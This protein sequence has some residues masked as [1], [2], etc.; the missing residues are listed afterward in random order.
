MAD[1]WDNAALQLGPVAYWPLDDDGVWADATGNGHDLTE[2]GTVA[3]G[4]LADGK[5]GAVFDG[6]TNRLDAADAAPLRPEFTDGWSISAWVQRDGAPGGQADYLGKLQV[7][8]VPDCGFLMGAWTSPEFAPNVKYGSGSGTAGPN[9]GTSNP[10]DRDQY[11]LGAFTAGTTFHMVWTMDYLNGVSTLYIDG[12]P[13][14]LQHYGNSLPHSWGSTSSTVGIPFAI[15]G[16]DGPNA[17]WP[18]KIAKVAYFDKV[19]TQTDVDDLYG[20][21]E[22]PPPAGPGGGEIHPPFNEPYYLGEQDDTS[23]AQG[24]LWTL[25]VGIAGREFMVDVTTRLYERTH[26]NLLRTRQNRQGSESVLTPPEIW[27]SVAE[28]W[29]QGA[30]QTRYDRDESLPY[31]FAD[32][33]GVDVWDE[34]GFSLLNKTTELLTFDGTSFPKLAVIGHGQLFCGYGTRVVWWADPVDGVQTP[35]ELGPVSAINGLTTDGQDVYTAHANGSVLKWE[36]NLAPAAPVSSVF[37]TGITFDGIWYLKGFLVASSGNLLY[38]ISTG[39][40]ALIYTHPNP[41]WRWVAGADG[42]N[43]GYVLGGV[44]DKWFVQALRIKDDATSFDPPFTAAS[45]PEGEVGHALGG[46]LG[47]IL[48]GTDHGVRFAAANQDASLLYGQLIETDQ[49]V[50]CFEGQGR[51][52]WYG[53]RPSGLGAGLGRIDLSVFTAPNTP[54]YANDLRADNAAQVCAH[55]AVSLATEPGVTGGLGYRVFGTKESLWLEIDDKVA[56]G[57]LDLGVLNMDTVD[58]KRAQYAQIT[59]E[60]LEGEVDLA[61]A[62]D[63]L[64]YA[65]VAKSNVQGTVNMGNRLLN[66]RKFVGA[67]PRIILKRSLLDPTAG[68][69]V[70]RFE[71]RAQAELGKAHEWTIP[72]I[73]SESLSWTTET[74]PRNVAQDFDFLTDLVET[75]RTFTLREGQ[76]EFDV[77]ATGERWLPNKLTLS[78]DT[79]Q[80]IY[81]LS[82]RQVR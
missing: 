78:G 22:P 71:L 30:G 31:R 67:L 10:Y 2:I 54:A 65:V 73:L 25:P 52:V 40:P 15:G 57:S 68:P 24:T 62:W 27:R 66:G 16:S 47:F 32:S 63:S 74:R 26:V 75:G 1:D 44:G 7:A 43:A 35:T 41:N 55:S 42:M 81:V 21:V 38:D 5:T 8:G 61:M 13:V 79:W 50:R 12:A 28:S 19:L 17:D 77:Y 36:A 45:L 14:T 58:A 39:T 72:L 37:T 59:F 80:G 33:E 76:R 20:G 53:C 34:W 11:L 56:E 48:I 4:L 3:T 64:N 82:V 69:R 23:T 29:H 70:T 51:F 9:G 18:G 60:P 46:Y 6:L 49:P